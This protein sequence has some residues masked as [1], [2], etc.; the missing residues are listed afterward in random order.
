MGTPNKRK[1][2]RDS[3]TKRGKQPPSRIGSPREGSSIVWPAG[4]CERLGIKP[5][6]RWRWEKDGKLPPRDAYING[7]AVGWRPATI[8]TALRGPAAAA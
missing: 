6:T 1:R 3:K 2:V 5:V 8:E 7:V 4:L